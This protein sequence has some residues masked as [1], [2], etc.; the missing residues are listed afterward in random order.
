M[1]GIGALLAVIN[2]LEDAE[3][4]AAQPIRRFYAREDAFALS[5]INFR[6][7]FRLNKDLTRN[8]IQELTPFLQGPTRASAVNIQTKASNMMYVSDTM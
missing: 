5:E 1:D 4:Q 6:K 3:E 8:L 2:D 7:L